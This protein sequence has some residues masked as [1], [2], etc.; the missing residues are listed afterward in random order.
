M[1]SGSAED[2]PDTLEARDQGVEIIPAVEYRERGAGGCR[3]LEPLHH[4]LRAVMTGTD[5][6]AAVVQHGADVV[7]VNPL[8]DEGEHARL[9]RGRP[10]LAKSGD[11]V[12]RFGSV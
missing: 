5:R 10:D 7:C 12:Q 2:R 8:Q 4:R 11:A 1:P 3:N 6:D 9:L